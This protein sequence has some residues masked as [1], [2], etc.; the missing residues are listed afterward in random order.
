MI[1][2]SVVVCAY[3]E[4]RWDDIVRAVDSLAGQSR[5]P[6]EILVVVDHNP[7]LARRATEQ[8]PGPLLV[9]VV[10]SDRP[11]GLSGARNTGLASAT[12]D[13]VAFLDDDA[14]ARP[15]WLEA[16]LAPFDDAA[17]VAVGGAAEPQWPDDSGAPAC[18]PLE[19]L[20]VVGC[21]YVRDEEDRDVR[22][23]MGCSMALR[24]SSALAL[25]G[26][27]ERLGRRGTAP[28]GCEETDLCIRLRQADAG[29]RVVLTPAAVVDHRVTPARTRWR[30][31]VRRCWGEGRSKATLSRLV[32]DG[33]GLATERSY[34][35]SAI[36]RAVWREFTIAV[37]GGGS[38]RRALGAA[39]A[40][41]LAVLVT[42]LAY[43]VG[44]VTSVASAGWTAQ[45]GLRRA[46]AL[47][48][49][50]LGAAA[51]VSAFVGAEG[52]TRL[53]VTVLF[54]VLGPGWAVAGFLRGAPVALVWT[55]ALAVGCAVGVL[56]GQAMVVAQEFHPVLALYLVALV[57]LPL[58]V[59]HAVAVR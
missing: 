25:G 5:G 29:A 12:G 7:D 49:L 17:V 31:L 28:S 4:D 6:D 32:G 35:V 24:R 33:D 8:W 16:I 26:F 51:S 55:I 53:A 9:S 38:R 59:R 1:T 58:L 57:C 41:P 15:G 54:L 48:L 18:L 3:T 39:V 43:F 11:R 13:V 2:T 19:L 36:P 52:P 44:L 42:A 50:V 47:A 30:Y 34:V 27:T 22:N 46:M 45:V 14:V 37:R 21:S 10:E 40:L 23:V 20:W 56:G